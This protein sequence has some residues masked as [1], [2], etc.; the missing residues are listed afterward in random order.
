MSR[1]AGDHSQFL[2][3]GAIAMPV[4]LLAGLGGAIVM[5]ILMG[6]R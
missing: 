1:G 2:K 4:A 6:K 3:V 5:Q